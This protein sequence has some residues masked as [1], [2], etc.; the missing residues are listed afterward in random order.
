[1]RDIE[2]GKVKFDHITAI[3]RKDLY[4]TFKGLASN[5]DEI[6]AKIQLSLIKPKFNKKKT[7]LLKFD[8]NLNLEHVSRF[9]KLLTK[10]NR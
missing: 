9:S 2:S 6:T 4:Q 10:F 3:R 5:N 1:M 8:L 7:L